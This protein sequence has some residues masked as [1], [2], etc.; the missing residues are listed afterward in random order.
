MNWSEGVLVVLELV[1]TNTLILY[2]KEH[3]LWV[4]CGMRGMPIYRCL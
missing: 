2:M 3:Y 1:S 4:D